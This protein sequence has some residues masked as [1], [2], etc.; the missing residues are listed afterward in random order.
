M[1]DNTNDMTEE[2]FVAAWRNQESVAWLVRGW[3]L[4]EDEDTDSDTNEEEDAK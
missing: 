1:S 3:D 2:E 4:Q